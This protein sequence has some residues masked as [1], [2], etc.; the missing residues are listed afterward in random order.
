MGI[1]VGDVG[2]AVTELAPGG[3]VEL[4]G[5]RYPARC[6]DGTIPAGAEVE[7]VRGEKTC[8]VVRRSGSGAPLPG[9]G[10]E[11]PP[12]GFE[13]LRSR[14]ARQER[15]EQSERR[16]ELGRRV[17]RGGAVSLVCG[18]VAGLASGGLGWHFDWAN[19]TATIDF[20]TLF[21]ASMGVGGAA[22]VALFFFTGWFAVHALPSEE[23]AVFEPSPVGVFA[24]LVGASLGFWLNFGDGAGVVA[25]WSAGFALAFAAVACAAVWLVGYVS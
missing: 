5:W 2:L 15:A 3:A 25:A 14:V 12:Q 8:Y 6:D 13:S 11:I 9:R 23:G 16:A 10:T 24:G 4:D 19:V 7:V 21:G 22:G 17:R 1:R 20:P 18:A